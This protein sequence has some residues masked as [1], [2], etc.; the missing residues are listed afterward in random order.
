MI[1]NPG[2]VPRKEIVSGENEP[3]PRRQIMQ[4]ALQD[5]ESQT[6]CPGFNSMGIGANL[7]GGVRG[8]IRSG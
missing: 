7:L 1:R 3:L 6:R 4:R 8:S 2:K 5:A